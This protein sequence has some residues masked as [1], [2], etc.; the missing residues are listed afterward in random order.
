MAVGCSVKMGGLSD[1][2]VT[3]II[4][5]VGVLRGSVTGAKMGVDS[6]SLGTTV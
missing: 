6:P 2:G 1:V 4:V 5:A 3:G